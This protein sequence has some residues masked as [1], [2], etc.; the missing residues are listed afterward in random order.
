MLKFPVTMQMV[1][2]F[3]GAFSHCVFQKWWNSNLQNTTHIWIVRAVT[4]CL[5]WTPG[6]ELISHKWIEISKIHDV[7]MSGFPPW[8]APFFNSSLPPHSSYKES[9]SPPCPADKALRSGPRTFTQAICYLC[10]EHSCPAFS[11]L[12]PIYTSN[13]SECLLWPPTPIKS[14]RWS[15]S[16]TGPSD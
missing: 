8:A 1:S 12:T 9:Q 14:L 6:R 7:S 4:L 2:S 16:V 5:A 11:H 3:N 15:W 13:C 10:L